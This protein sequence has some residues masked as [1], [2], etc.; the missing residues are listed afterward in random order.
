MESSVCY[1]LSMARDILVLLELLL[2]VLLPLVRLAVLSVEEMERCHRGLGEGESPARHNGVSGKAELP[3][4]G[5]L[6]EQG[7]VCAAPWSW[8][9]DA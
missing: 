4:R 5:R 3:A 6:V 9:N 1:H 2:K 7:R 8:C